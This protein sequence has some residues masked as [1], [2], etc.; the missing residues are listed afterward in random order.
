MLR[1]FFGTLVVSAGSRPAARASALSCSKKACVRR[2]TESQAQ[3]CVCAGHTDTGGGALQDDAQT[4]GG[5]CADGSKGAR[6]KR[7]P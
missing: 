2:E 7:G 5:V 1:Y 6:S 3:R 4:C